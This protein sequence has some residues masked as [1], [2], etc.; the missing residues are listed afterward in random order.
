MTVL[1]PYQY[2]L[3]GIVF[4]RDTQIP[5]QKL[6]MQPYN[7]N[8]QDFQVQRSDE[9]RFGVDTLAPSPMVFTMSVMNNFE[10]DSMAGYDSL[11]PGNL[12]AGNNSALS[13]LAAV[14]KNPPLRMTWGAT[15]PLTTTVNASRLDGDGDSWLRVL[16]YGPAVHPIITYGSHTIEL[17]STIP[18]GVIVEISSYPWARRIVDSNGLNRRTELVG[19]TLYL[20][21]IKFPA[22]TNMDITWTCTGSSAATELYFLW[23]ESYNII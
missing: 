17:N 18:P 4:G 16:V 6:D 21:Q 3:N 8:N 7:V 10:L 9:N 20:D 12:F 15:V 11:E 14:W 23:R 22:E 13:Q 1:Q 2:Y 19:S 5:I